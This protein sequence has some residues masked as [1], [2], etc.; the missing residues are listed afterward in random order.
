MKRI[1]LSI[2]IVLFSANT[3]AGSWY[4]WW[5]S[6]PFSTLSD[7]ESH[8]KSMV[9]YPEID[10]TDY[11]RPDYSSF[12]QSSAGGLLRRYWGKVKS[13]WPNK[14]SSRWS[15]RVL[16]KLLLS[17]AEER[18][19]NLHEGSFVKKVTPVPGVKFVMWGNL[20]GAYHSLVRSLSELYKQKIIDNNLKIKKKNYSFV[21][22][23]NVIDFSP[24]SMETL[25]VV[26]ML[27]K[28]NPQNVFYV[29][30][31]HEYRNMWGKHGLRKELQGKVKKTKHFISFEKNL[32]EFF[33]TLPIGLY[34]RKKTG[35]L[36]QFVQ[37]S[38]GNM[39]DRGH[40]K[41]FFKEFLYAPD[42]GKPQVFKLTKRNSEK[43]NPVSIDLYIDAENGL[44]CLSEHKGLKKRGVENGAP[45]WSL[46]AGQNRTSRAMREFFYDSFVIFSLN[47]S[48]TRSTFSLFSRDTRNEKSEFSKTTYL[49]FSKPAPLTLYSKFV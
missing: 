24:F 29:R 15:P 37:I 4:K 19:L 31:A 2:L 21:F 13:W 14:K 9:E 1:I 10:N 46:F 30:G 47:D 16:Q 3:Y 27:M 23:G 11:L 49:A 33:G 12:Y 45:T 20:H 32:H 18:K 25:T 28:K 26:L 8:A 42:Y 39:V 44:S 7:L 43:Y 38:N 17:V 22:D 34:L 5:G 35:M 41:S 40:G 6:K 48:L 36:T